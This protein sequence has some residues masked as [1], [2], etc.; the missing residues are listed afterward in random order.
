[1]STLSF[2]RV[3][4][5]AICVLAAWIFLSAYNEAKAKLR[6]SAV[7]P[8]VGRVEI[9]N[10]GPSQIPFT[11]IQ[12]TTSDLSHPNQTG[13]VGVQ[14][15]FDFLAPNEILVLQDSNSSFGGCLSP[16]CKFSV[17]PDAIGVTIPNSG[18]PYS[19]GVTTGGTLESYFQFAFQDVSTEGFSSDL[20]SI[21]SSAGIWTN[22]ND[23]FRFPPSHAEITS[24]FNPTGPGSYRSGPFPE[25]ATTS[26]IV[27]LV[28]TITLQ[29][30]VFGR[31]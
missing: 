14:N 28:A 25:P 27:V 18:W 30:G 16:M 6:I 15:P 24:N 7:W 21:A 23:F 26:L 2:R 19:I 29:R 4:L 17:D 13:F 22:P 1:M 10:D 9:T 20:A 11:G 31:N 3:W 5:G 8:Y 12:I